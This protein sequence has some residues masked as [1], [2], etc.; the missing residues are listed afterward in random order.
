VRA[1]KH[2]GPL[3]GGTQTHLVT[4][5][6]IVRRT[7]SIITVLFALIPC[8]G[9]SQSATDVAA[10]KG[11]APVTVLSNTPE[12]SAAF[13]ANYTATGSI[14][15]GALRQATLLPLAE[16]QQALRDVYITTGNLAQLADG[17]GTTLGSAYVARLIERISRMR[18]KRSQTS[19]LTPLPRQRGTPIQASISS[20]TLRP[21]GSNPSQP[22]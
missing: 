19:S 6:Q 18:L 4:R 12:G 11:L 22:T 2:R 13:A 8:Q 9:R 10:L 21:T 14:Q 1:T 3:F 15:T 17:L 16:Q 7:L 5:R 20:R